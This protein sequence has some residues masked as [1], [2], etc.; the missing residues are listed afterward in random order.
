[1]ALRQEQLPTA[2][3]V[4]ANQ[5][6][7]FHIPAGR[8]VHIVWLTI[9]EA[10]NNVTL[11][12]GNLLGDVQ[13]I[14]NSKTVRQVTGVQ[15]NHINASIDADCAVKTAGVQ[16]NAG[17]QTMIPILFAEPG[18]KDPRQIRG[19]A[20]D[21]NGLGS[22]GMDIKVRIGNLTTPTI[23]GWYEWEPSDAPLGFIS[24]YVRKTYGSVGSIV[25]D[26]KLD[27]GNEL[28]QAMHFFP[29]TDNKY[30]YQLDFKAGND[31]YRKEITYLQNQSSLINRG[32]NPDVGASPVYD[33]PF[34]YDDPVDQWLNS[35]Q[36]PSLA[37]RATLSASS[38]GNMDVV[39]VRVGTVG[40]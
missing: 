26:T 3:G 33:L 38:T 37:F 31:Y 2:T 19:S 7:F 22:G 20:W 11:L 1:M 6:A 32:L 23:A 29:T 34:D 17:Y 28:Y 9:T 8:R 14:V 35:A 10:T 25:E 21:L 39:S 36:F 18:R 16:G 4:A 30:V 13:V 40:N 12:S 24:K 5:D 15:L 27:T